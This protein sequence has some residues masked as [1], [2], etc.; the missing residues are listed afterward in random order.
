MNE[1]ETDVDAEEDSPVAGDLL[2]SL[3]DDGIAHAFLMLDDGIMESP[4]C[5]SGARDAGEASEKDVVCNGCLEAMV[6]A[7][8]PDPIFVDGVM[9]A[10]RQISARRR[11]GRENA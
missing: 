8:S 9:R 6:Q 11:A 7:M 4:V 2:V 5:G 10:V 1:T 3:C